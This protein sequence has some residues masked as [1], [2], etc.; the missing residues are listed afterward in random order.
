MPKQDDVSTLMP[1]ILMPPEGVFVGGRVWYEDIEDRRVV[2]HGSQP[3]AS[4]HV[5][6]KWYHRLC[7]AQ[8]A[9]AKLA[10]ILMICKNMSVP[11]R[12]LARDRERLVNE[13]VEGFV[14]RPGPT[15]P[16][17]IDR[18]VEGVVVRLHQQGLSSMQIADSLSISNSSVRNV[19]R[20][21]GL[22]TSK[23]AAAPAP[24]LPVF[25]EQNSDDDASSAIEQASDPADINASLAD[26]QASTQAD[27]ANKTDH[28][29]VGGEA[30]AIQ[31]TTSLRDSAFA[32][33]DV[34][35]DVPATQTAHKADTQL[36]DPI[37]D[38][39][40][41]IATDSS[42]AA[43]TANA[44]DADT[45]AAGPTPSLDDVEATSVPYA[46]PIG[47]FAARFG[48]IDEAPADFVSSA[49]TPFAGVLLGL[50]LLGHTGLMQE[51]RS[52]Y[53]RMSNGWY[54]LRSFFWIVIEMALLRIRRFE[55]LKGYDPIELG[56]TLGLPRIAEVK[57]MRRKLKELIARGKAAILHR[58][59][60]KR[61]AKANESNLAT[62]Y[63][64]GHTRV[65]TG[66]RRIGKKYVTRL[67][68]V[69]RAEMDA[70]VHMSNGQPLL[71]VHA[72]KDEKLTELFPSILKEI[73][74][75]IGDERRVRIVFDRE[76][77]CK[78][79]FRQ[80]LDAGFDLITYRKGS[81]D[82]ISDD[83]FECL[84]VTTDGGQQVEYE[85]AESVFDQPGWPK[86]R[87][88]AV[89][90]KDG[91]QTH[92]V[93]SG[94]ATWE[95]R[96]QASGTPDDP[97]E[98]VAF[99]MF[100]RWSQEN[101]LKYS[102]ENYGLDILV[103]YDVELDDQD[104]E[105]PNR[106]WKQRDKEV[107]R[108]RSQLEHRKAKFGEARLKHDAILEAL[109]S[110]EVTVRDTTGTEPSQTKGQTHAVSDAAPS[111]PA[112]GQAHAGTKVDQSPPKGQ[113]PVDSIAY[114]SSTTRSPR[115]S[116]L[117]REEAASRA[118]LAVL[119]AEVDDSEVALKAALA[120]RSE[121]PQRIRLGDCENRD[122]IKLSY[123]G[124]LLMDTI[125]LC[126]YDVETMLFN[127]IPA[128]FKGS[129]KEGRT[130]IRDILRS[131]GD[132]AYDASERRLKVHLN[133]LS[134]PRYTEAMIAICKQVNEQS[135][136]LADTDIK[137][138]FNVKPRPIDEPTN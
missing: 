31:S 12:T 104:R 25:Q 10:P 56:R 99:A 48:L 126:A 59:L 73:R 74:E 120:S 2:Y 34:E 105:V 49:N 107:S 69:S 38:S 27:Q 65:Y 98:Q 88:I 78:K 131:S 46:S 93:T 75:V 90:R 81:F 62:L 7:A 110:I 92:I 97:K 85:V 132:L 67:N 64:D 115:Q 138:E 130:L 94:Q 108:L 4:Y 121:V 76:C 100:G 30:D 33:H 119:S 43:I 124:K 54:G 53:G 112:T 42:S 89:K 26:D 80:I 102:R 70:W 91:Q 40:A 55:N 117:K 60:A 101:W 18:K 47:Q 63:V 134:A 68:I 109:S 66:K 17:K 61:R 41:C 95:S 44:V 36:A 96:G 23:I 103:D 137:I 71:V 50:S 87:L 5:D 29:G 123:E 84:T 82:P 116:K 9:E 13:G 16:S 11:Q 3:F 79:T 1:G 106:E 8:L 122:S 22:P 72:A 14:T 35:H 136:K 19:L 20:S 77:W 128:S 58:A 39:A 24:L 83:K 45:D 37:L 21:K 127:L 118:R 86:L 111:F 15:K 52:I 6:D 32:E 51:A 133:Q 135:P 114:P 28:A 125:K 129:S 57:T 113:T